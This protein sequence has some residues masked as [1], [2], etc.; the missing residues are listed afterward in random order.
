[1][2]I[3]GQSTSYNLNVPVGSTPEQK[4]LMLQGQGWSFEQA[5]YYA[6]KGVSGAVEGHST[7][8]AP[9]HLTAT[10]A[11]RPA[12]ASGEIVRITPPGYKRLTNC[13]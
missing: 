1:M 5:G 9:L 8:Q 7:R 10:V 3:Y 4:R 6:N 12:S 2:S 11:K 13:C